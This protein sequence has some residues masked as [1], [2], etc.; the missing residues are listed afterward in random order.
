MILLT[1]LSP[2]EKGN[3]H[4]A[5][6]NWWSPHYTVRRLLLGSPHLLI[7]WT[8]PLLDGSVLLWIV[9]RQ[10]ILGS[11]CKY[12]VGDGVHPEA[13]LDCDHW[14]IG[15]TSVSDSHLIE[16]VPVNSSLVPVATQVN[17]HNSV[18]KISAPCSLAENASAARGTMFFWFK[19]RQICR[20]SSVKSQRQR[21]RERFR[22]TATYSSYFPHATFTS[23]GCGISRSLS[24]LAQV[25]TAHHT[26]SFRQ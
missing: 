22:W 10:S 5:P 9:S 4:F 8:Y 13:F 23:V 14:E 3:H 15:P 18:A 1:V 11:C 19:V 21:E 24:T 12:L 17:V 6:L 20:L 7:G 16:E 26:S 25:S 2:L